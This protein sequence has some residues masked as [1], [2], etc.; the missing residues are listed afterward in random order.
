MAKLF[1]I[2]APAVIAEIEVP[3]RDGVGA[4]RKVA[5]L[6]PSAATY[7][8]VL[9]LSKEVAGGGDGEGASAGA[10]AVTV[11]PG[12]QFSKFVDMILLLAPGLERADVAECMSAEELPE[13]IAFLMQQIEERS[14]A[15]EEEDLANPFSGKPSPSGGSSGSPSTRS[16]ASS[17]ATSG[18]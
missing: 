6:A 13:L 15:R 4:P 8:R 1:K 10:S 7:S 2:K 17:P 5:M 16:T 11:D 3:A 9:A 12:A 14:K 18:T